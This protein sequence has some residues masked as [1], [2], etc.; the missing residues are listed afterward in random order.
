MK[1]GKIVQV[2]GPVVDVQFEDGYIAYGLTYYSFLKGM[3]THPDTTLNA[4]AAERHLGET[5]TSK[6]GLPMKII[7]WG[8]KQDIDVEFSDGY[9]NKH[10]TYYN[11]RRGSISH[12]SDTS[13]QFTDK[14]GATG[15]SSKGQKMVVEVYR[16]NKDLD[17][18]FEDGTLVQH[19]V[20]NDFKKG[21]ITNPNYTKSTYINRV[22]ISA[23]GIKVTVVDRKD[24]KVHLQY[25]T[26][27]TTT[28]DCRADTF[29]DFKL[30][31]PYPYT[32]GDVVLVKP[33]YI[34]GTTG[35]FYCKCNKCTMSDILTV[36]EAR[37]HICQD[38]S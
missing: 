38:L 29:V 3:V 34:Y 14:T 9:V 30:K 11:F 35:N 22:I 12:P 10:R 13:I 4:K 33:A 31:H 23:D 28:R 27:Y 26:G 24:F 2:M 20:F 21:L 19:K 1:E 36:Q 32:I 6:H 15:I 17:V 16:N 7:R 18:R 8:S 25:E 37:N 5:H